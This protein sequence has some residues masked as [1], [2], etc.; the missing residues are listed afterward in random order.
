LFITP[1]IDNLQHPGRIDNLIACAGAAFPDFRPSVTWMTCKWFA[2]MSNESDKSSVPQ[3]PPDKEGEGSVGERQRIRVTGGDPWA[4]RP[5][6]VPETP[7]RRQPR[8]KT[9]TEIRDQN[10]GRTVRKQS[11]V[12]GGLFAILAFIIYLGT[13]VLAPSFVIELESGEGTVMV[14]GTTAGKTG[15]IITVTPGEHELIVLPDDFDVIAEPQ[16]F[17]FTFHYSLKTIPLHVQIIRKQNII[18]SEPDSLTAHERG[19]LP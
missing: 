1:V 9:E 6:V 16:S 11:S 13:Q 3:I 7:S 15:E 18:P 19:E 14:D 17:H 12:L 4:P 8:Q 10:R 2:K 5:H